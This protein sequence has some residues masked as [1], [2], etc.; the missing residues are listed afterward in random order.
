[1]TVWKAAATRPPRLS[2]RPAL[3][4]RRLDARRN[5]AAGRGRTSFV[6]GT[7]GSADSSSRS[8]TIRSP[9]ARGTAVLAERRGSG[10]CSTGSPTRAPSGSSTI[11]A[12]RGRG[13]TST[14]SWSADGASS[15]STP[16]TTP[17][18]SSSGGRARSGPP[19]PARLVVAGR[20]RSTLLDGVRRQIEVVQRSLR[21]SEGGGPVAVTGALCF[22]NADF[23]AFGKPYEFDDVAVHWP[24][25]LSKL[26]QRDGAFGPAMVASITDTL[27]EAL[28]P[29]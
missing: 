2:P 25:S 3:P 18:G 5:I 13:R 17:G 16:R 23:P 10:G 22:W 21:R 19:G 29:A 8:P 12:S 11:D 9:P 7:L 15:S 14:T 27:A 4:V 24:R 20:D 1:M 6:R 28:R 26:V